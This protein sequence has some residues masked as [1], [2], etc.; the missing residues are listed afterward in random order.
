MEDIK[1]NK[2]NKKK[3]KDYFEIIFISVSIFMFLLLIFSIQWIKESLYTA[4]DQ[5]A[6]E[7]VQE[8]K[9]GLVL[10]VNDPLVGVKGS[11]LES[12][13][14]SPI[15]NKQDPSMG[16]E[17]AKVKIFYFSDFSCP[18]CLE[19][20]EIIK[21][22]YDKFSQDI[23]IIWKDYPDLNSLEDFSYQAAKA[24]RCAHEQGEFWNYNKLLYK[25]GDNTVVS[26]KQLFINL[27]ENLKLNIDNFNNCL[28]SS[29]IDNA[30][31][32]NV[33]EAEELG[34]VG[35]PYIY[36]NDIDMIADIS[37][38]ELENII[39]IELSK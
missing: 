22:V 38:E 31:M 7:F 16:P 29:R 35:I 13:L 36:I 33:L 9:D 8:Y 19:Q 20:E 30:I 15:D 4:K 17:N 25:E 18:F 3:K 32:N 37:E 2:N 5:V 26:Q 14:E 39:E 27:A 21:R 23:R 10:E 34:I 6:S 12:N 24:A 28:L 11:A 1:K